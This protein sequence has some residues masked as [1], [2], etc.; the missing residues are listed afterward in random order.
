MVD[1]SLNKALLTRLLRY[2]Q[3][4]TTSDASS[5]TV[6]ST[7]QQ[8]DLLNLLK[9]EMQALG[10]SDIT[11][12]ENG[13]LFAT[14]PATV[15]KPVPVLGL[16]AHVDTSPA[17]NGKNVKPQVIEQYDGSDILLTGSGDKLSV[18]VF[19]SLNKL[20]GHT[21]VTTDGTSLLGADV[22]PS[23]IMATVSSF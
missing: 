7:P 22:V 17:F 15:N 20:V 21:L 14:I 9:D 8:W 2:T 10:L 4:H 5:Q 23:P 3:I 11:L 1:I 16:L 6:P 19:P 12:D 18:K 13:Y